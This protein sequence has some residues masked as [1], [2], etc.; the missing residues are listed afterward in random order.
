MGVGESLRF[1]A[2][3][4]LGAAAAVAGLGGQG[5]YDAAGII[6]R[7]CGAEGVG[8]VQGI[9]CFT[10]NA[11]ADAAAWALESARLAV[12]AAMQPPSS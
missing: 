9:H 3:G 7:L 2:R 11:V 6:M 1:V 8:T 5:R 4:G 10:F 12:A